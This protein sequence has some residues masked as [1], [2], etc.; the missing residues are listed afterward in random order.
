MSADVTASDSRAR[1]AI[2]ALIGHEAWAIIRRST[3][4]GDR[5]TVGLIGGS[6]SEV[7][8]LL[9][10]PLESG[11]PEPG[12]VADRLLAIPFRQVAERGF[13]AHDDGTPLVVV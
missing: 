11:P 3:R 7:D 9:D 12:R 5:D 10:V 2:D 8:S 4:V 6:R 13:E 1:A